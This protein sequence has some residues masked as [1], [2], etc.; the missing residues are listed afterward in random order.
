MAANKLEVYAAVST[1]P[2]HTHSEDESC[3]MQ[4]PDDTA[5][6]LSVHSVIWIIPAL[7]SMKLVSSILRQHFTEQK[8]KQDASECQ[9]QPNFITSVA[10]GG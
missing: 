6:L 4:T 8:W 10:F 5:A 9:L 1:E 7:L 2:L 3:T